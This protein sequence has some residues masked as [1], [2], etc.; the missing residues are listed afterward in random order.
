M[1]STYYCHAI[2]GR[3]DFRIVYVKG[4]SCHDVQ[5]VCVN[6]VEELGLLGYNV[7]EVNVEKK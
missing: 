1:F 4:Q 5:V 2:R 3:E 6:S 7:A